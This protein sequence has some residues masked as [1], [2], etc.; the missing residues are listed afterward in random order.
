MGEK[1]DVWWN[2]Q[3]VRKTGEH[4]E[5]EDEDEQDDA[6]QLEIKIQLLQQHGQPQGNGSGKTVAIASGNN[7]SSGGNSSGGNNTSTS[8]ESP[9]TSIPTSTSSE[10]PS[11]SIR[12]PVYLLR[13]ESRPPEFPEPEERRV[14]FISAQTIYDVEE[15]DVL[16]WRTNGSN[17]Q[18]SVNE[19]RGAVSTSPLSQVEASMTMRHLADATATGTRAKED[20]VGEADTINA[21]VDAIVGGLMEKMFG[22]YQQ[23]PLSQQQNLAVVMKAASERMKQECKEEMRAK[24]QRWLHQ[25]QQQQQQIA[26]PAPNTNT[27]DV[28]ID[29]TAADVTTVLARIGPELAALREQ[30]RSGQLLGGVLQ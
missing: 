11:T 2:A 24:Q 20:V 13:Y 30:L 26:E 7:E 17:W 8:S 5:L 1:Q 16:C 12:M 25:R 6:T 21:L 28:P 14:C 4:H 27:S 18:P 9:S 3:V 19:R 10:S 15:G 22:R 29:F 23:L